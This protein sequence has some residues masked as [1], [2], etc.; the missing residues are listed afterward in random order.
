[1]ATKPRKKTLPLKKWTNP[2]AWAVW[3][4]RRLNK[5]RSIKPAESG[6]YT[7][8]YTGEYT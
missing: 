2:L 7:S 8:E 6:E 5:L 3:N 4:Q 1:M